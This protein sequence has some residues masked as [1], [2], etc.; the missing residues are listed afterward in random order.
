MRNKDLYQIHLTIAIVEN[1]T[2]IQNMSPS[3]QK[4]GIRPRDIIYKKNLSSLNL[5]L[6]AIMTSLECANL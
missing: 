5:S 3:V 2:W 6:D 1:L 4:D